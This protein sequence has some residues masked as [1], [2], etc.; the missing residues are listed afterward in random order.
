MPTV[1]QLPAQLD[2]ECVAGDPFTI[3]VTSSGATITSPTLTIRDGL[4]AVVA[5]SPTVS[6]A[7]AVTTVAFSAANT[8]ALKSSGQTKAEYL[9]SLSALVD[10]QGPFQL[11]ARSLTVWPV[12]TAGVATSSAASLAVT[13]GGAAVSLS[14]ALGIGAGAL[15]AANNLSDLTNAATARTNLG[16]GTA[17]TTAASAYA[18]VMHIGTP[19]WRTGGYASFPLFA[20]STTGASA[21]NGNLHFVPAMFDRDTTVDRIACEVAGTPGSTGS[22]HRLGIWTDS[23][24]APGTLLLDAGTVATDSTGFKEITISQALSGRTVYW[25]GAVQQGAPAT[26]ASLRGTFWRAPIMPT[27]LSFAVTT[28][29]LTSG[30]TGALSSSPTVVS[31]A[32]SVAPAIA[33]RVS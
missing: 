25:L 16:L 31:D 17:A 20:A 4:G 13:V 18:P 12:G 23:N 15:I 27:S 22:L 1:S 2:A 26:R 6:Q 28:S 29:W 32:N 3:S 9:F 19:I 5:V 24:G 10:G 21:A 14:V 7:G 30:V 8:T 33:L 11:I